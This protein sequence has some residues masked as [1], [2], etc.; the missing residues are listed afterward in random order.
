M[1]VSL[2][3]SVLNSFSSFELAEVVVQDV[4]RRSVLVG[5]GATHVLW[6]TITPREEIKGN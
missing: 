2:Q 3:V 5:D 4:I 6:S 1:L